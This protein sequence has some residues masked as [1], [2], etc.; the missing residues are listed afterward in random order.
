MVKHQ[1]CIAFAAPPRRLQVPA[2]ESQP[3]HFRQRP[4]AR[5]WKSPQRVQSLP[6]A[7]G[8]HSPGGPN[9]LC[10]IPIPGSEGKQKMLET[11]RMLR[12]AHCICPV[13][14]ME[15]MACKP[16]AGNTGL[17]RF[18]STPSQWNHHHPNLQIWAPDIR[19][20]Q[21]CAGSHQRTDWKLLSERRPPSVRNIASLKSEAGD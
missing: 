15:G 9:P 20:H 11:S 18:R 14:K 1:G 12:S 8:K 4:S 16:S 17:C 10:V 7:P 5:T 3:G 19:H 13:G 6:S 2:G 21:S